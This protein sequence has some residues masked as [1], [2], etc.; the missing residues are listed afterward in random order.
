MKIS[1]ILAL[2]LVLTLSV[3]LF[4]QTKIKNSQAADTLK[5]MPLEKNDTGAAKKNYQR[6]D[7][8]KKQE[9]ERFLK[10]W[11]SKFFVIQNAKGTK[12]IWFLFYII[13]NNFKLFTF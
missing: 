5:T 8:E 1:C 11:R 2:F 9:F 12:S 7:S 3:P 10:E 6:Y 13:F 4:A